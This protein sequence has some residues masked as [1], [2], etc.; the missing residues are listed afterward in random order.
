MHW[1]QLQQLW[2][3][4]VRVVAMRGV[5]CHV[6]RGSG[7]NPTC[8]VAV[9]GRRERAAWLNT[10]PNTPGMREGSGSWLRGAD[11]GEE[12]VLLSADRGVRWQ[13]P[14]TGAGVQVMVCGVPDDWLAV[15]PAELRGRVVTQTTLS[16]TRPAHSL[17]TQS[18]CTW[19]PLMVRAVTAACTAHCMRTDSH[20]P[21]LACACASAW[22]PPLAC[23]LLAR[24]TQQA[25]PAPH[26]TAAG[27]C[28]YRRLQQLCIAHHCC[29]RLPFCA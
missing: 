28:C 11:N 9:F 2:L 10:T 5:P 14:L 22:T 4:G 3:P 26:V 18:L 1:R 15:S 19:P 25:P 20:T 12:A 6:R 13:L 24:P 21:R 16:L 29:Y 23:T 27:P 8:C 17:C 7:R